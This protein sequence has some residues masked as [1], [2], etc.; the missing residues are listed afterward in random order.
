MAY[1][2]LYREYEE[3]VRARD[4]LLQVR[5][6]AEDQLEQLD[7]MI[8]LKKKAVQLQSKGVSS[9]AVLKVSDGMDDGP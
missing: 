3:A 6:H 4:F 5:S 7:L 9:G 1:K 8:S 2:V